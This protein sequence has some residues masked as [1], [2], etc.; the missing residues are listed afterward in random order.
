MST[1]KQKA[2]LEQYIALLEEA[3]IRYLAMDHAASGHTHLLPTFAR[4]FC[5]LQLRMICELIALACLTAHGD[6]S[7]TKTKR[8]REEYSASDIL[9]WLEKLHPR[10]YPLPVE[11]KRIGRV[12]KMKDADLDYLSKADLIAL[13]GRTGDVLHRGSI[14]YIQS[15][16]PQF[17][18]GFDE[19]IKW[20]A[21]ISNL[22]G[23][24]TIV[25]HDDKKII[26]CVWYAANKGGQCT[27][28]FAD[29]E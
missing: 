4:E 27:A 24:H 14:T 6:I 8:F 16:K 17:L 23:Q 22:L 10:F 25:T 13:Y 29:A 21:K 5:F 1:P 15:G 28:T 7:E 12:A 2:A 9:K 18:D 11:T 26:H 19:V 3:K 20:A